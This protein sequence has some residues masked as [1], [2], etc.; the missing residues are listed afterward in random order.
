MVTVGAG[1]KEVKAKAEGEI[2]AF[3]IALTVAAGSVDTKLKM[4]GETVIL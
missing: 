1:S 4:L 2:V 3:L